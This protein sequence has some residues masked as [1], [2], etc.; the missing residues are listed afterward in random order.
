MEQAFHLLD[1][2]KVL[3]AAALC[4]DPDGRVQLDGSGYGTRPCTLTDLR[5]AAK[6]GN[7]TVQVTVDHGA[8][9]KIAELYHP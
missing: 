8:A 1:S 9:T 3:G 4:G 5:K 2:T 6:L 7:V